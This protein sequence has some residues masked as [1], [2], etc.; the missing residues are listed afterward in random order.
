MKLITLYRNDFKVNAEANYF[1]DVLSELGIPQHKWDSIDEIELKVEEFKFIN[2]V[3]EEEEY[4]A[5]E[6]N[7]CNVCGQGT[8]NIK[9]VMGQYTCPS[10]A[11]EIN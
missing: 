10:C 11:K 4:E 5:E 7:Y 9:I 6:K 1:E 8:Y 2:E 3:E